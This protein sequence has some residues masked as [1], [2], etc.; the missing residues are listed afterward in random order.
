MKF[1]SV[2]LR[3]YIDVP[4]DKVQYITAKNGRRAAQ[5]EVE[6]AGKKIKLMKFVGKQEGGQ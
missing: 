2:Q 3:E 5:A 1:Y 4:D 6:R